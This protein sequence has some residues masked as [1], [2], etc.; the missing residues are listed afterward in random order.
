MLGTDSGA[1]TTSVALIR[2]NGPL[3]CLLVDLES[4]I[5][6]DLLALGA[7][8]AKRLVDAGDRRDVVAF[9]RDVLEGASTELA[10]VLDATTL[11]V[12]DETLVD[13]GKDL[14]TLVDG[15][16][17]NLN[18]RGTSDHELD[19]VLPGG[20]TTDT[21][22]G[23][24]RELTGE[25]SD[26]VKG[27]GTDSFTREP[28]LAAWTTEKRTLSLDIERKAGTEGVHDD[29]ASDTALLELVSKGDKIVTVRAE[30]GKDRLL[31]EA[32]DGKSIVLS[33]LE[34]SVV[35]G[36]LVGINILLH[37][38]DKLSCIIGVVT[39]RA[40]ERKL[41]RSRMSTDLLI[42]TAGT[43]PGLRREVSPE[44]DVEHAVGGA[45]GGSCHAGT[46]DL[47]SLDTDG[48]GDKTTTTTISRAVQDLC[49]TGGGTSSSED[50]GLEL[51]ALD[52]NLKAV[53]VRHAWL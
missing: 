42:L 6:A 2:V 52:L 31:G 33:G 3:L 12:G 32:A 20:D 45:T 30:L 38:G 39:Q 46:G 9:L 1:K 40:D 23:S 5:V 4:T 18:G 47:G 26:I 13:L 29:K 24:V 34:V 43:I 49:V 36:E 19:N 41:A 27:D 35:A 14:R 50:G 10:D 8:D 53:S 44:L 51:E 37:V 28:A 21:D 16:S 22:D 17:A 48:L 15:S 11:Q 7:V 25:L